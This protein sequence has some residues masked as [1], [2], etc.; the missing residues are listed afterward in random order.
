MMLMMMRTKAMILGN[1][2][3]EEGWGRVCSPPGSMRQRSGS[4]LRCNQPQVFECCS[5]KT[6]E[7]DLVKKKFV[8]LHFFMPSDADAKLARQ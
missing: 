3:V 2:A 6:P 4:L 5:R 1:I 8:L 7:N